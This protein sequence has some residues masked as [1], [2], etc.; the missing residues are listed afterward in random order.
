MA[1]ILAALP[2]LILYGGALLALDAFPI[3]FRFRRL[4][5]VVAYFAAALAVVWQ[6]RASD[7][8]VTLFASSDALPYLSLTIWWGGA[9]L[10]LS[11]LVLLLFAASTLMWQS[12]ETQTMRLGGLVTAAGAIL[13]LAAD[14]WTTVTAAWLLVEFGLVIIPADD[15]PDRDAPARAFGWNLGALVA[16][17]A[18]GLILANEASSLRLADASVQGLAA[19]L[20]F[21]AIWIRCGLYPFQAAAP[22]NTASIGIRLGLPL[23]LGGSL[24]T[25]LA[26]DTAGPMLFQE[27]AQIIAL[28]AVGVSA[29]VVVGQADQSDGLVWA[30][31]AFGAPLLLILFLVPGPLAAAA[32]LW[33]AIA[34]FAAAQL[35]GIALLWR[36]QL[37]SLPLT[38]VLWFVLLAV[39]AML[40]LTPAF[41]SRV[42]LLE[43]VYASGQLSMWLVLV[44]ALALA[45]IPLWREVFASREVAPKAATR[46]EYAALALLLVPI[47]AAGVLPGVFAALFGDTLNEGAQRAYNA[48]LNPTSTAA[49]I[50]AL[51]GLVVPLLISFELARRWT[52]GVNLIPL[53]LTHALELVG[54]ARALD[55][56]YRFVRALIQQGM[57]VLEQP[58]IAWM[59]FLAIWVAVWLGGL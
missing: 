47:L 59:I 12:R 5:P 53:P 26:L 7:A 31:R 4:I 49:L 30:L 17:L 19:L 18:A 44:G 2:A 50:F 20:A 34:A 6:A 58:P 22:T 24:M 37:P 3:P 27:W 52:R 51:A 29:L 43:E 55:L 46:Y 41:W 1:V 38:T 45:L 10:P 13:F 8:P 36:A 56:T 16:W 32:T 9:A 40:P 33:L 35:A 25:H 21:M 39:V 15:N 42:G 14:N 28:L 57:T 48:I 54:V 11:L 23:L